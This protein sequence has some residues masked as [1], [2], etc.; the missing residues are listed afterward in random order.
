VSSPY[1]YLTFEL[2]PELFKVCS[3]SVSYDAV[4]LS[5]ILNHSGLE[6]NDEVH[7]PHSGW[8]KRHCQCVADSQ[9]LPFKW[10]A[11]DPFNSLPYLRLIKAC[12][13]SLSGT[14][15]RWVVEAAL[16][17][18]WQQGLDP[19][20]PESFAALRALLAPQL[21]PEFQAMDDPTQAPE[22]QAA[23][24]ASNALAIEQGIMGAPTIR[25]GSQW[26]N[27]LDRMEVLAEVLRKAGD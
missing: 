21:L 14:P 8:I 2:L 1:A 26:Y 7:A 15:G 3:Y 11:R 19:A 20:E 9:G 12:A 24:E 27:G 5:Q 18:L 22:V 4:H 16:R 13:P 17:H 6:P 23:V 25:Y 10:P